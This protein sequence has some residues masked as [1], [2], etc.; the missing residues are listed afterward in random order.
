VR[1][2][3]AGY[4]PGRWSPNRRNMTLEAAQRAAF[5]D[6]ERRRLEILQSGHDAYAAAMPQPGDSDVTDAEIIDWPGPGNPGQNA[7]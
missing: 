1:S 3:V 6:I 7:G 5:A 2:F 4:S